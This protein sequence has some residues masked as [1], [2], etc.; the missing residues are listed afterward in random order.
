MQK[1][2]E[3]LDKESDKAYEAFRLYLEARSITKVVQI[4]NKS[5]ALIGR[6]S[7]EHDW[8]NRAA[9]FDSSVVEEM[10]R[11]QIESYKAFLN[12]Q[13]DANLQMQTRMMKVLSEKDINK[14][15]WRTLNEI[16]R[17]NF[18]EMCAIAEKLGITAGADDNELIIRIENAERQES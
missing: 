10:R 1:P 8:K 13:F 7:S 11:A 9:A 17:A 12:K 14:I 4:L 18:A 2:W 3:R 16:Y 6:W 5:R 15:S